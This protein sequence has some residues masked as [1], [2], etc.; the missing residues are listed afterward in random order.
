M[1]MTAVTQMISM[2]TSEVIVRSRVIIGLYTSD[3]QRSTTG[4]KFITGS[5]TQSNDYNWYNFEN[6]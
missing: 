4:S 3:D 5:W 1:N 6:Q 2:F